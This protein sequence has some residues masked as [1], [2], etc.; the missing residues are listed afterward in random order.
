MKKMKVYHAKSF[1]NFTIDEKDEKMFLYAFNVS[2]YPE[3]LIRNLNYY[4]IN[5]ILEVEGKK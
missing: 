4:N 5:Y 1:Y 3:H 2:C